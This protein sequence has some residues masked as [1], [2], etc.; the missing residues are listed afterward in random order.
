MATVA[1]MQYNLG[2]IA[3]FMSANLNQGQQVENRI[4][5]ILTHQQ[6]N[7]TFLILASFSESHS[8]RGG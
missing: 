5:S 1:H 3:S 4:L 7:L 6:E 8:N 2:P